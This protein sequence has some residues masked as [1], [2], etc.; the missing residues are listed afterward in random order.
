MRRYRGEI[1]ISLL[2]FGIVLAVFGPV[3]GAEFVAWDDDVLLYDNPHLTGLGGEALRWMWGAFDYVV[4]Y[5]PLTWMTW[6]V[7]FAVSGRA[8]AAYHAANLVF[9][10]LNAVLVFLLLRR[11]LTLSGHETS[12]R[13]PT[14]D[15][16]VASAAGALFWA[17]HPLRVETVAWASALLH[18]QAIFFLLV[19]ALSYVEAASRSRRWLFLVSVVAYAAS[20]FSY[21]VGLGFPAVLVVLEIYPLRRFGAGRSLRVWARQVPFVAVAGVCVGITLWARMHV[22]GG[23]M[24]AAPWSEFGPAHRVMQAAYVWACYLWK[25]FLPFPLAPVYT[26]LLSFQPGDAAFVA[27]LVFLVAITVWVWVERRAWPAA[28]PL[29][30]SYLAL[31]VPFLGLTEHPHYANDRYSN[32]GGIVLSLAGVAAV[33]HWCR[34]PGARRL[35]LGAALGLIA[36]CAALSAAQVKVWRNSEALFRHTIATLGS[37][38]YRAD[39]H[40]RLGRLYVAQGRNQDGL[41]Q[42]ITALR[43]APDF[44]EAHFDLGVA[45]E[46]LGRKADAATEYE[47]ALRL[48]PQYAEAHYRLALLLRERGEASSA[49]AHL[50][51]AL[52]ADPRHARARQRLQEWENPGGR[53][54]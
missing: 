49:L 16:L 4:R 18:A 32:L 40:W 37:D 30:A 26:P 41:A 10:A 25:P 11:L 43:I 14:R 35:A 5:Q 47:R 46:K 23:W 9:H 53:V 52:A 13:G 19:S 6:G 15:A 34:E 24:E 39:L 54:L 31:L 8:P 33:L 3:V 42:L 28:L 27:S 44:A 20:L 12:A 7:I 2:V 48:K 45:W 50:R 1:L 29:W 36:G 22:A 17:L 21:P 38:P 51:Q